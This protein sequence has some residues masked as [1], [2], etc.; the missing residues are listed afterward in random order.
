MAGGG[1]AVPVIVP[2]AVTV[3]TGVAEDD[4]ELA[5]VPVDDAV[6]DTVLEAEPV[7]DAV[8]VGT[9]VCVVALDG[10]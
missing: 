9:G 5:L 6:K 2:V 1:V 8:P 7:L 4:T 3:L 10:V